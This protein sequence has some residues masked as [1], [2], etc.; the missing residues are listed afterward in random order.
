MDR[1]RRALGLGGS[2]RACPCA[3]GLRDRLRARVEGLRV[4]DPD[5]RHGSDL[6]HQHQRRKPDH[7]GDAPV[8]R[9]SHAAGLAKPENRDVVAPNHDTLYSIAWLDLSRQPQVLHVPKMHRF[10]VFELVSPWTENFRNI[11]T[12]TGQQDGGDFA[13]VGPGL[14][15]QAAARRD[16][17]AVAV[18]PRLDDRAH[19]HQGRGRH[20]GG[21]TRS[22]TSYGLRRC[23]SFGET[24]S[25]PAIKP[26]DTTVDH[27]PIAGLGPGEDPL[28]FYAV[29][30]RADERFPP[31]AADAPLLDAA[32][33]DRGRPRPRP[34]HGPEAER[35]DARGNARRGHRGARRTCRPRS[36]GVTWTSSTSTTAI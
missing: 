11:G 4:R 18:Q 19:L 25:P 32:D 26:V 27:P 13:I 29:A 33:R 31:P 10:Y 20:R 35:R 36:R 23:K 22:R 15:R 34:E 2:D 7:A 24:Y 16:Q 8:N 3:I 5:R 30:R 14:R 6:P 1:G 9:F 12:T 17:G 28:A 21:S